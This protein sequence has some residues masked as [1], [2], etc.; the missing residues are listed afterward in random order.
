MKIETKFIAM[1]ILAICGILFTSCGL[2]TRATPDGCLLAG[3][4]RED[5]TKVYAGYCQ[6]GRY[7][8]QWD[9]VQT[10]GSEVQIR[11]TRH[12]D[13]RTS[14]EY[15][16]GTLWLRW[17]DKSGVQIGPVPDVATEQVAR[18]NI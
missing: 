3:K 12:K 9:A 18:S 2:D 10:D 15:Q 14:I 17:D 16:S 7:L 1:I 5:G 11:Y 6:D 13:G 4:A 8:A